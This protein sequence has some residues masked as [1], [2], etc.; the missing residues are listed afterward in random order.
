MVDSQFWV[1]ALLLIELCGPVGVLWIEPRSTAD[2]AKCLK[3]SNI[4]RMRPFLIYILFFSVYP[5][6]YFFYSLYYLSEFKAQ[7][8]YFH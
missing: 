4:T 5:S 3:P 2:K 1:Q 8:I 6:L 7:S